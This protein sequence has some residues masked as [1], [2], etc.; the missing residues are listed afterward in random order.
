M[1]FELKA[2]HLIRNGGGLRRFDMAPGQ[3]R[4]IYNYHLNQLAGINARAFAVVVDKAAADVSG[5]ACL[6]IAWETLLQRLERT[7]SQE[8]TDVMVIHDQGED[9]ALRAILRRARRHMTSGTYFGSGTIRMPLQRLIEDPVPRVSHESYF[10]QLA[11][12]V[13]YAGWRT[14]MAPG[15]G[16]ARVADEHTWDQRGTA[17]HSAVNSLSRRG[18]PGVVLR[19]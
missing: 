7:T 4:L 11:D 18:R 14:H 12:L 9:A 17:V 13:A 3:R 16:A 10:L 2:N 8:Q 15:P 5:T 19:Y 6:E 1:R